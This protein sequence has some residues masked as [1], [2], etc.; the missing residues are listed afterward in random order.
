MNSK[1]SQMDVVILVIS[2]QVRQI[3]FFVPSETFDYIIDY[4]RTK[5]NSKNC[6]FD[7][8]LISAI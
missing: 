7:A 1:G 6:H 8:W 4:S 5:I 3:R 2:Y